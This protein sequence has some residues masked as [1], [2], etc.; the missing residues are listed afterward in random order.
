MLYNLFKEMRK[1]KIHPPIK[2]FLVPRDGKEIVNSSYLSFISHHK[3]FYFFIF[4]ILTKE[5]MN[6]FFHFYPFR[7]RIEK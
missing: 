3:K 6:L 1:K 7:Q 2:D 4:S 5:K